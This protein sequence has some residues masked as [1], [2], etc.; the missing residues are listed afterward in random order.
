M[1]VRVPNVSRA[2]IGKV[3]LPLAAVQYVVLEAVAAAAWHD[4]PYNYA[5]NF[6]SDLGNPVAGDVFDGRTINSPLHLVMDTAFIAQGVL[7]AAAAVLLHPLYRAAGR[8]LGKALLVLAVLHG[9]G[10]I[11][12]GLFPESAAALTNGVI[13]AH[14]IGA[15]TTIITGN[16][17]AIVVAAAGRGLAVPAWHRVL[18]FTLGVLGLAAF[19]LLQVNHSLYVSAGGVPERIAVYT[20][21]AWEAVTGIALLVSRTGVR[22]I[23]S[24]TMKKESIA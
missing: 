20:I 6:I 12:V 10:V 15:A 16:V 18:G 23:T 7:F 22:P 24:A 14:G 8:R 5:V 13:I 1:A 2:V 19:V 17:I 4:P 3:L 9:I 21:I 11:M